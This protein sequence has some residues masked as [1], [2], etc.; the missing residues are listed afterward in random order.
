MSDHVSICDANYIWQE[1]ILLFE[2]KDSP[3]S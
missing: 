2:Q 1:Q 3:F